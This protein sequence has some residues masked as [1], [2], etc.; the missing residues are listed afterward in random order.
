METNSKLN[1][2]RVLIVVD[3]QVD[4]FDGGRLQV[5]NSLGIIPKINELTKMEMFDF[6]VITKDWHPANHKSFASQ[7]NKNVFDTVMLNGIQQ[8]LWPDHCVQDTEGAE[9]HPDIDLKIKNLYIFKKGMNP[10]VDSYSAFYENDGVTSTGLTEFLKDNGVECVDI[11]GLAYDYCV[12]YTALD[13]AKNFKTRVI[14]DVTQYI[15]EE[16]AE[17]A[18]QLMLENGVSVI[19]ISQQRMQFCYNI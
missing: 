12:S 16:T 4:F 19:N 3:P 13:S 1:G 15:S 9:I 10:E 5:A 18:T 14:Q 7:H 17:K 6:V 11:V 8:T 2:K